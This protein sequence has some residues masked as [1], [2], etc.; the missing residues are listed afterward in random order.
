VNGELRLSTFDEVMK[1]W[2][3]IGRYDRWNL[4]AFADP[5]ENVI[6]GLTYKWSKNVELIGNYL[7][8]KDPRTNSE[9]DKL[10]FT[11][12]VNW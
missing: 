5:R 4:D 1:N 9:S 8:E 11:A 6:A 3:V 7:G 2:N 12:E 10:M